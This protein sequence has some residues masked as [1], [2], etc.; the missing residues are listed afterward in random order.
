MDRSVLT[1]TCRRA[2][3]DALSDI[4]LGHP[5]TTT[6]YYLYHH[7]RCPVVMFSN[8]LLA[9]KIK[10][11]ERKE[12]QIYPKELHRVLNPGTCRQQVAPIL[13]CSWSTTVPVSATCWVISLPPQ[14][15]NQMG[16]G[17][18]PLCE[19]LAGP[20]SRECPLCAISAARSTSVPSSGRIHCKC[21]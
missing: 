7:N 1:Q 21:G 17:F 8:V 4:T 20:D 12:L 16:S 11:M 2:A 3:T 6:T 10:Q 18:S 9:G 5:Y 14:E 19:G 13:C 15:H